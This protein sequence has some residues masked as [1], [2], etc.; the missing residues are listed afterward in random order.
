MFNGMASTTREHY[1]IP[2][3]TCAPV[4]QSKMQLMIEHH[5]RADGLWL[6]PLKKTRLGWV[7]GPAE[8][9]YITHSTPPL[10]LGLLTSRARLPVQ[11]LYVFMYTPGCLWGEGCSVDKQLDELE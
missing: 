8:K 1:F 2:L 11:E 9:Y 5:H 3:T 4:R 10:F 6:S 7:Q